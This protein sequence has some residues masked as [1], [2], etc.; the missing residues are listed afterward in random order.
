[1]RPRLLLAAIC[2]IAL[3]ILSSPSMGEKSTKSSPFV[4]VAIAGHR[5]SAI[6]VRAARKTVFA[7]PAKPAATSARRRRTGKGIPLGHVPARAL[8]WIP[9]P[10]S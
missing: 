8:L 10:A 9:A 5:S 1:M 4:A 7:I 6:G 2:M 3:P